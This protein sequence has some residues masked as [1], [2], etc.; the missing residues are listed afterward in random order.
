MTIKF[1]VDE[2]RPFYGKFWPGDEVP[3]QLDYD[4]SWTLNDLLEDAVKK[5]P[6][7][8]V[9]WFLDTWVTF[10]EFKNMVDKFA[11]SLHNMGIRKGDVIAIYLPNSIQYCVSF[12]G[13]IKIGA[14]PSGINPTYK[15]GEILH[16]IKMINAHYIV[17][18]DS[19]YEENITE[20]INEWNF[21]KVIYTNIADLATGM[22]KIKI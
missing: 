4:Y 9:I 10:K 14:I 22:S 12:Y 6:N 5:F 17:A 19:L 18:L 20:I 1:P 2:N 7:D 21:E 15:P 8:T 11:T 3:H 16:Q 13:A